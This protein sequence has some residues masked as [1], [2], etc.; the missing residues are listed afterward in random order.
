MKIDVVSRCSRRLDFTAKS[1]WPDV[2]PSIA[3]DSVWVAGFGR[4]AEASCLFISR[5]EHSLESVLAGLYPKLGFVDLSR[6]AEALEKLSLPF[7]WSDFSA[8]LG[9]HWNN[10][11]PL[12]FKILRQASPEVIEWWQSRDV[13]ARDLAP[14]K[15]LAGDERLTEWFSLANRTVAFQPSRSD[16]VQILE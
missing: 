14:L 16:G 4:N 5:E 8:R 1:D 11:W 10:D 6:L 7:D 12:L 2:L 9:F 13:S 15:A 3:W